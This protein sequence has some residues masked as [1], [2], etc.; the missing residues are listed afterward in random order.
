MVNSSI[1]T[2]VVQGVVPVCTMLSAEGFSDLGYNSGFMDVAQADLA[3]S[4]SWME[5]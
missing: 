4:S 3:A 2:L 5:F 1:A